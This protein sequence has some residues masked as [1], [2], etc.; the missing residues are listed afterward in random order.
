LA[1]AQALFGRQPIAHVTLSDRWPLRSQDGAS[2]A[3]GCVVSPSG[4]LIIHL[5]PGPLFTLLQ[6]DKV[7]EWLTTRGAVAPSGSDLV[8]RHYGSSEAAMT[9]LSAAC[10]A[11]GRTLAG[12]PPL[13][14]GPAAV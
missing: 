12:L 13:P 5:L 3:F 9:A 2:F 10:V 11:H 8:D 4:G 1:K 6:G 14:C 7:A